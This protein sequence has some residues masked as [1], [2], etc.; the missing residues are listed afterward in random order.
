MINKWKCFTWDSADL[1]T[2]LN[3][4]QIIRSSPAS[5]W[6]CTNPTP[7]HK[8]C[9]CRSQFIS[10]CAHS[11]GPK[12]GLTK[13]SF[14]WIEQYLG[15]TA[16]WN[17]LNPSKSSIPSWGLWKH[18]H[19]DQFYRKESSGASSRQCNSFP[20]PS[21]SQDARQDLS[22]GSVCT[23][24]STAKQKKSQVHLQTQST[25]TELG[26]LGIEMQWDSWHS[27]SAITDGC[28]FRYEE[29]G[30]KLWSRAYG[31]EWDGR[32]TIRGVS[33][34]SATNHQ[35]G[36]KADEIRQ[37]ADK[38]F[39]LP[40]LLLPGDF[41]NPSICWKGNKEGLK[42]MNQEGIEDNFLRSVIGQE[43]YS[44]HSATRGPKWNKHAKVDQ[45]WLQS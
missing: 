34:V 8:S 15:T 33:W 23:Q 45:C 26:S 31:S 43:G 25:Y 39:W 42:A 4:D 20:R 27:C 7:D 38:T 37:S 21:R 14:P 1:Q 22:Q 28:L 35:N 3:S 36:E 9:I 18:W 17:L 12:K 16:F 10:S 41:H 2:V 5:F 19:Q 32:P 30:Q 11:L 40:D 29:K 44:A 24:I 6:R 13:G